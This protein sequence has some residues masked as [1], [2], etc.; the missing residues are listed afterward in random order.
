MEDLCPQRQYRDFYDAVNDP[1]GVELNDVKTRIKCAHIRGKLR[2]K[3]QMRDHKSSNI[4]KQ[5]EHLLI[6]KIASKNIT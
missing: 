2:N 3:R 1:S 5:A 6:Q 4:Y